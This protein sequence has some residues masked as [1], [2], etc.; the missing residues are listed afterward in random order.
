M[1]ALRPWGA[2]FKAD[3][4]DLTLTIHNGVLFA[5]WVYCGMALSWVRLST[6]AVRRYVC[7]DAVRPWK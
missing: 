2:T 3:K 1:N 4:V 6:S 7:G 5:L